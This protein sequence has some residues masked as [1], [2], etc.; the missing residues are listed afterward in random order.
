MHAA[1]ALLQVC[2]PLVQAAAPDPV[3]AA[4]AEACGEGQLP[5]GDSVGAH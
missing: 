5:H 4:A 2:A 3:H 1:F